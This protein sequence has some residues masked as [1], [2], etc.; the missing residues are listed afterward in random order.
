MGIVVNGTPT[1]FIQPQRGLRQGDPL[2]Q[3]LFLISTEGVTGLIQHFVGR[4]KLHGIKVSSSSP[5]L[6]HLSFA[7]DSILFCK[8]TE[9]EMD[10]VKHV[11]DL[12]ANGS[13]QQGLGFGKYLGLKFEFGHSKKEV[14]EEIRDK[15]ATRVHGWAENFLTTAGN[16]VL[17]KAVA[18]ALP[19]ACV[20]ISFA[21]SLLFGGVAKVLA[22]VTLGKMED[23]DT[24][25]G[26]TC[27]AL[28]VL[29]LPRLVGAYYRSQICCFIRCC[30]AWAK[31]IIGMV[32]YFKR[33]AC[34]NGRAK[35]VYWRQKV[36]PCYT[37]SVV[38]D[39]L[40]LQG[41]GVAVELD[42]NGLLDY[43]GV[44]ELV[45]IEEE[46]GYGNQSGD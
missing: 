28:T 35:M 30:P 26:M 25:E 12:Y 13:G 38:A 36:S 45:L 6:S 44:E 10:M 46:D 41:Y 14:F 2:S 1:G 22:R 18:L 5:P 21:R 3:Y 19:T 4:G 8:A 39:T 42:S 27:F 16:E 43:E 37:R 33:L 34:V 9:G 31:A 17:L 7:D 11:L 32:K 40:P 15:V 20:R 29:C 24:E 23:T